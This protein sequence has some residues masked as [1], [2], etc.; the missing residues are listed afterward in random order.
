M[1]TYL[2][3]FVDEQQRSWFWYFHLVELW[4]NIVYHS[5]IDMTH[6]RALYGH[7]LT[8]LLDYVLGN[9]KDKILNKTLQNRNTIM[10][11]LKSNL[12]KSQHKSNV[13]KDK[14]RKEPLE[15]KVVFKPH[16]LYIVL[17]VVVQSLDC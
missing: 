8:S 16:C 3:C 10:R 15:G 1:E 13:E 11:T 4:Y 7:N 5:S 12:A 14:H 9:S 2:R 6:F 17:Q